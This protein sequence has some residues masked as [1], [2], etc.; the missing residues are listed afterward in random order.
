MINTK[1]TKIYKNKD[2]GLG[3]AIG[4]S[5]CKQDKDSYWYSIEFRFYILKYLFSFSIKI[6]KKKEIPF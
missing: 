4:T 5:S 3:A 6:N 1:P 2:W